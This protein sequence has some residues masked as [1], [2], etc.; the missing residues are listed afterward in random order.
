ME[1]SIMAQITLANFSNTTPAAPAGRQN[2]QFLRDS[3]GNISGN[4]PTLPGA[5]GAATATGDG[6]N[7]TVTLAAT[8]T[9]TGLDKAATPS[10]VARAIPQHAGTNAQT[11][12]TVNRTQALAGFVRCPG[13]G[14]AVK[15]TNAVPA[16]ATLNIA[17][18]G[19]A[20][21]YYKGAA[22]TEFMIPAGHLAEF[23]YNGTQWELLNPYIDVRS[24]T[25]AYTAGTTAL[26][27][28]AVYLQYE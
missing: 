28:G 24:G 4:I 15:F 6:T 20:A 11:A 23:M 25:T 5:A 2:I 17:T 12:A 10:L 9:L 7:G 8:N 22:I 14:V 18:T 27:T 26:P 16:S 21:I 13:A 1:D 3:N 19:Q